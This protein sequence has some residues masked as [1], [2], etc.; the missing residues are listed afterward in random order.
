LLG[1]NGDVR[2]KDRRA[3]EALLERGVHVTLCTGRMFSGTQPIALELG[4][5]APLACVDG[6][7]VAHSRSGKQL[8]CTPLCGPALETLLSIL[9]D[10]EAAAYAFS[11]ELLFH[12]EFG[13]RYLDYVRAWSRRTRLVSDLLVSTAWQESCA[14]PAVL[15][16][17]SEERMREA[18][19]ALLTRAP[20]GLQGVCFESLCDEDEYGRRP[21]ALLVRAAGVD[22][23]TGIE[24]L[25]AHYGVSLD[26]IVTVGDWLNDIPMLSRAGLSFAMA[27][28][29]EVVKAAASMVLECDDVR[30]GGIAEAAERAG[31]L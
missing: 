7:H 21:W 12:D 11:D 22:K 15:A 27:Q 13:E 2:P 4:I 10:H 29:P 19:R 1:P 5:D 25:A 31:L 20:D 16:L 8:A 3:I 24:W 30:G 26:E 9:V 23:G 14:I 18:E 28:S 17:G 6:S